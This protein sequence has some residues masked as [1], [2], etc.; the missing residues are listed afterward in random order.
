MLLISRELKVRYKQTALGAIWVILQP[1][2]P[3]LIFAVVL[4]SFARLPSGGT[5]YFLFALSGL[6]MYGLFSNACSRAAA[7]FLRDGQLITKVYVPR[8]VLP[9]AA[10]TAAA[11]DFAVG[12]A[13]V[14]VLMVA[15]GVAPTVVIVAAPLI[16]AVVLALGLALGLAL[17]ALSARYRDFAIAVPFLL[18]VLLY[19]SP[20][21]YSS[22]LVPESLRAVYGLNPLVELIDA[23]RSSLLGT[24]GPTPVDLGLSLG[25]AAVA[26]VCAVFVF[27]RAS[28]DMTD[29]L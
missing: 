8:A 9:L 27:S 11:V 1:L 5:P 13:V 24:S 10:G 2:V 21:V 3:A 6:V 7:S 14:L 16:A 4:G 12:G 26:V 23:F 19:A 20:V 29:V 22:E 28:R 25:I 18:Q 15:A 17:A